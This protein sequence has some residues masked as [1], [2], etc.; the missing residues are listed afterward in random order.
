V[1][2]FGHSGTQAYVLKASGINAMAIMRIHR[3]FQLLKSF[4]QKCG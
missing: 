1:D 4:C 2:P 3:L